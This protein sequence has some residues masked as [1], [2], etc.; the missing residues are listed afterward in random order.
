M[1]HMLLILFLSISACS[2]SEMKGINTEIDSTL[3]PD[4]VLI[5]YLSRTSNTKTIA[6][7]I[8]NNVGGNLVALQYS[9]ERFDIR[10][11]RFDIL[12]F[13]CLYL[14]SFACKKK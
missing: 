12:N 13:I 9:S 4:K 10:N 14:S 2:S 8:H 7:I 1:M 6:E 5:V 3:N 11:K